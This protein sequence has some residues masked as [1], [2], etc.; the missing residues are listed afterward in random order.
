[1]SPAVRE[2]AYSDEE[3][4]LDVVWASGEHSRYRFFDVPPEVFNWLL[5]QKSKGGFIRRKIIGTYREIRIDSRAPHP[6]K[7]EELLALLSKSIE[8][9]GTVAPPI[10]G[11]SADDEQE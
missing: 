9:I 4:T 10:A 7:D 8:A 6:S 1:M 2:L 5:E 3:R 11:Q